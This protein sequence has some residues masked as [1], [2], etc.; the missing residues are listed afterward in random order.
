MTVRL[1]LD[2]GTNSVGSAW[3][4]DKNQTVTLGVSVF[5]AGVD[6][7]DTKRGSPKNQ[8][9]RQVRS[10]RRSLRRRAT[11]KHRLRSLLVQYGLLP[12]ESDAQRELFNNNPWML[13]RE[14]LRR[15][16]TPSEFGRVLVHLNQRRGAMGV[17]TDPD[18]PDEGKVKEAIDHLK[19]QLKGRTFGQFMA[20]LMDERV[21]SLPGKDGVCYRAPIRN[22]RDSFEFH[23]DREMI[24]EEFD[25][26]WAKQKSFGGELAALLTDDLKRRLDDPTEDDT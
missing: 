6:E 25:Q 9:R 5:P 19:T 4:D 24:R 8:K 20:D 22:R 2:I 18:D 13:R 10:Q 3:V 7:T 14:G 12:S 17:A 15:E 21:C 26:V 23:A 11:R 16:L 1:G